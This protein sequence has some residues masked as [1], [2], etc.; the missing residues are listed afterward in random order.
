MALQ[1]QPSEKLVAFIKTLASDVDC[2]TNVK[3]IRDS[4]E[5]TF[6]TN[7]DL[8]WIGNHVK[9]VNHP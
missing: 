9:K 2:P 4:V 3:F 1:I 7:Q 8:R 6:L 5:N